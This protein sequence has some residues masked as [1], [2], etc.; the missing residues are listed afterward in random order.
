MILIKKGFL[1]A[2][3]K[4]GRDFFL[5]LIRLMIKIMII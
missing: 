1:F 5:P 4:L 2:S 3:Q